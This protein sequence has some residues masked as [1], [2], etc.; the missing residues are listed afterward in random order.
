MKQFYPTKLAF[1][2]F[3][4]LLSLFD[5]LYGQCPVRAFANPSS[6]YCGDSVSL[7]AIPAGCKPLNND[8]NTGTIGTWQSTSGGTVVNGSVS[9]WTCM[10]ASPDPPYYFFMGSSQ[11]LPRELKSNSLNLTTCGSNPSAGGSVCWLMKYSFQGQSGT[12]EGPDAKGEGVNLQY[13][14]NGGGA[15][16]PLGTWDPNGGNDGTLTNWNQYCVTLPAAA[17]TAN[18][19]FRWN[20]TANSGAGYDTWAIDDVQVIMNVP[21]YKFDWMHDS[22]GASASSFTPKITPAGNGAYT[23]TYS[24]K[25]TGGTDTCSASVNVT[26]TQPSVSATAT[27]STICLGNTSQL[28]ALSSYIQAPPAVCGLSSSNTCNAVT[29]VAAE[30]QVGTGTIVQSLNA[31]NGSST[32]PTPFGNSFYHGNTRTQILFL[33][34]ELVTGG[35]KAGKITTLQF[36]IGNMDDTNGDPTTATP[37]A[38][39][40]LSIRM[41]CT[42]S[43]AVTAAYIEGLPTVFNS[44]TVSLSMGWNYFTFDKYFDWDGNSNILIDIC[45]SGGNSSDFSGIYPVS[46]TTTF[47]SVL[48]SRESDGSPWFSCT[49]FDNSVLSSSNLS[50]TRPNVIFGTCEPKTGLTLNYNWSPNTALSSS[51]IKNPVASPTANTAYSVTVYPGTATYCVASAS[52]N[53]NVTSASVSISPPAPVV[54]TATP[55]VTLT[56]TASPSATTYLWSPATKLSSTTVQSPK[57]SP[58]VNTTYTVKTT[59]A[60]GC[61]ATSSVI[62]GWCAAVPISL[63]ERLSAKA[64]TDFILVQWMTGVEIN[65]AYFT[66]EHSYDG[67]TY[68]DIGTVPGKGNS[69]V[70]VKYTFKDPHPL[71]GINYYRLKQV[72]FNGSYKYTDIAS[73]FYNMNGYNLDLVNLQPVPVKGELGF[74]AITREGTYLSIEILDIEGKVIKMETQKVEEGD[75]ALH[76]DLSD[77]PQGVYLLKATSKQGD[78]ALKRFIK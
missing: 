37:Y 28:D 32:S 2:F 10:G 54:C 24:N 12:C 7:T 19:M 13:S 53:V 11:A 65:N 35:L 73:A 14:T 64:M 51:T 52:V 60:N 8:F 43:N 33:K 44:K 49:A 41:T 17:I 25:S 9:P 40:N 34:S 66:V 77:L 55:T 56:A 68:Q 59:D 16:N 61:T 58:T 4:I 48:F 72:D 22:Q 74:H 76:I 45:W 63:L 62:V 1:F 70:A 30:H 75:T 18:T 26:V 36:N 57:A 67:I 69:D 31:G 20:Q 21:G 38:C 3:F 71:K 23:I 27:P 29:S 47:N 46:H 15:W 42:G 50:K 78:F 39:T 6:I 5:N